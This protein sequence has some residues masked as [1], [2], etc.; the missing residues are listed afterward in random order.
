MT[1]SLP[2][3]FITPYITWKDAEESKRIPLDEMIKKTFKE[4][5][6]KKELSEKR[7]SFI[8]RSAKKS[9]ETNASVTLSSEE[10][11][12]QIDQ[13]KK[14]IIKLEEILDKREVSSKKINDSLESQGTSP[15]LGLLTLFESFPSPDVVAADMLANISTLP[16]LKLSSE[17]CKRLITDEKSSKKRKVWFSSE[18]KNEDADKMKRMKNR[19]NWIGYT[20]PMYQFGINKGKSNKKS[21][22]ARDDCPGSVA[23]GRKPEPIEFTTVA[24]NIKRACKFCFIV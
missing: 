14:R 21:I 4:T 19:V 5:F 15:E 17:P 23:K 3:W 9:L 13:L 11:K 1:T 22:H 2:K 8:F 12:H 16:V 7:F 10:I 18:T 24:D 6:P 20:G